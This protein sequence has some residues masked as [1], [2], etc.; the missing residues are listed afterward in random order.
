M[1]KLTSPIP[2]L[3]VTSPHVEFVDGVAEVD[4]ATAE[5]VLPHLAALGVGRAEAEAAP[6]AETKPAAKPKAARAK[7]SG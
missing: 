5:Q 4:E 6:E 3:L 1:V 2:Q 7:T